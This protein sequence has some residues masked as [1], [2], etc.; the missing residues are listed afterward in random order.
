MDLETALQACR[1]LHYA[2]AMALFGT[3]AFLAVLAPK[4][5]AGRLEVRLRF[6]LTAAA[7]LAATTTLAWLMLKTGEIG[8]GW[9]D[10]LDPSLLAS[11][12]TDSSF[13]RA[14]QWRLAFAICL[15]VVFLLGERRLP[16]IA[17]CSGLLLASLALTGHAAMLSGWPGLL[18]RGNHMLHLL[19]AGAWLGALIPLLPCLAMLEGA[20][21]SASAGRALRRFSTAGHVAV[22]LVVVTG[23]ANTAFVLGHPPADWSSPYQALLAAKIGLVGV[24]IALALTNRYFLV[25]RIRLARARSLWLLSCLTAAELVLGAG[26]LILV[27]LFGMIEPT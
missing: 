1:F 12:L 23:I 20:P 26:V 3:S 2:A 27:S 15:P 11:V 22:S 14:W 19:A 18:Q 6:L 21:P 8:D 9:A 16:A 10:T 7:G 4:E 17:C 25:P 5:L 13:G 24:M